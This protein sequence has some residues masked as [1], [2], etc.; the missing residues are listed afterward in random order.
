[1]RTPKLASASSIYKLYSII[2]AARRPRG[3]EPRRP[4]T[5]ALQQASLQASEAMDTKTYRH[6]GLDLG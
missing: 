3:R 4:I 2:Y 1:M 6:L 5:H